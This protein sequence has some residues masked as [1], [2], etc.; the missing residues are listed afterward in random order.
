MKKK[1]VILGS[2]GSIGKITFNIFKKDKI[3]FDIVL[4]STN[5]NLNILIKQANIFNVKNLI[6][7]DFK[8]FIYAKKKYKKFNFY[9]SFSSIDE[10]LKNNEIY[11]TMNSIVGLDGLYPTMQIIKKTKKIAIVNKEAII[12]GWNLIKKKVKK[13]KKI[14]IPIDSEHF[15]IFS[16][17]KNDK[18][19]QV[20]KVYITASGGPFLKKK[21]N[22]SK[23]ISIQSAIKHPKWKMGKK[24]SIDSS[25]LMNKVFE[26]IEAKNIFGV[27]YNKIS[28]FTHPNSY[29]HSIVKFNNG[30]TKLLIHE[31]DMKIP[32]FNSIYDGSK[33]LPKNL[34]LNINYLN[35][36]ELK[37]ISASKF[38]LIKILKLLPTKNTLFE[39][40]VV[41]IN[42]FFV[43]KFLKKKINYNQMIRYI[44]NTINSKEILKFRKIE[45]INLKDIQSLRSYLGFKLNKIGI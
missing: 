20:E 39:T 16:L 44:F 4:L 40:A 14:F 10:I 36:L 22:M 43:Y 3:N 13:Y 45:V 17:I 30:I 33:K 42:D 38:P 34:S 8:K 9:N 35:N 1:V 11:Y 29:L 25:T 37:V 23:N 28:V 24:I 21:N 32:I 26:V 27:P 5:K 41:I 7:T 15:S 19:S 6:I 18:I 2:T 31:P 12:C